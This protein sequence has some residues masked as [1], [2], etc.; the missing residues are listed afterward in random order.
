MHR[1]LKV[2]TKKSRELPCIFLLLC[3]NKLTVDWPISVRA[4][5]VRSTVSIPLL[6][7]FVTSGSYPDADVGVFPEILYNIIQE[8]SGSVWEIFTAFALAVT[9]GARLPEDEFI[10]VNMRFL[11]RLLQRI[12]SKLNVVVLCSEKKTEFTLKDEMMTTCFKM[13]EVLTAITNV[14]LNK[15]E[16]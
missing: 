3:A 14:R 2:L 11:G 6:A 16:C 15:N 8:D 12:K 1:G 9:E 5:S 7:L 10:H 4:S 13:G